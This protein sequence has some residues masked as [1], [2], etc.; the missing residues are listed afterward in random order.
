MN[1]NQDTRPDDFSDI[2]AQLAEEWELGNE[3]NQP[4]VTTPLYHYTSAVGLI[5]IFRS[6]KL[7][8]TSLFHM[9]DPSE[10]RHGLK[11][12]SR[13][14]RAH[15]KDDGSNIDKARLAFANVFERILRLSEP[16]PFTH[17]LAC[18]SKARDELGQWR[19]YGD[20]GRGFAIGFA[21]QVFQPD[22]EAI[23]APG[24][25]LTIRNVHYDA[26]AAEAN[27]RPRID[28]AL[29]LLEST[30]TSDQRVRDLK[31]AAKSMHR[32]AATLL[33]E[34]LHQSLAYKHEAYRA[35]EESRL[36]CMNVREDLAKHVL[37]RA[38][39]ATLVSYIENDIAVRKP[40][41]VIEIVIGPSAHIDAEDAVGSL[42]ASYDLLKQVKISR[43]AIPYR[44]VR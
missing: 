39:G 41:N 14:V 19:A 33:V 6:Q 37:T 22:G 36:I 34:L 35:E 7:W 44:S 1:Q 12:A 8:F 10:L 16:L 15:V 42:L 28:R 9:N 30:I 32:I 2:A 25:A 21:P 3:S 43:S 26:D 18:F 11:I 40:G 13:L 20:D 29:A 23:T 27:M 17:F 4:V 38:R 24:G 31:S 5:E